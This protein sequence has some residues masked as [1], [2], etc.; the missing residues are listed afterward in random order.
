MFVTMQDIFRTINDFGELTHPESENFLTVAELH[1]KN[2]I[3]I[4]TFL[5]QISSRDE[6]FMNLS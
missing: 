1:A 2:S 4:L 3:G 6:N 5:P